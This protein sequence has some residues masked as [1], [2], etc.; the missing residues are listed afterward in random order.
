MEWKE[1]YPEW[2][3][4]DYKRHIKAWKGFCHRVARFTPD[5][6]RILEVGFGTG[7][8][9][10]YLALSG[11]SVMGIDTEPE[12]VRRAEKLAK[13][14]EVIV[15]FRQGDIFNIDTKIGVFNTSF[16]QG[17]LEHFDVPK[18]KEIIDIQFSLAGVVAFCVPLDRFG[19][20]SFGDEILRSEKEWKKIVKGNK[21][22]YW[23]TFAGGKHLICIL[24]RK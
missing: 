12:F 23:E 14:L 18:I 21:V 2:V 16:S 13:D 4:E 24:R 15:Y 5:G 19:H 1:F 17:F 22:E 8:M 11:Y 6:G 7:Q 20:K 3:I 9:S 10:I